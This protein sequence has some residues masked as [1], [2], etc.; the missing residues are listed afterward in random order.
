M[1]DR[2]YERW[3]ELRDREAT[4]SP[5]STLDREFCERMVLEHPLCAREDAML[6]E[7]ADLSATPD[8]GSRE[9]EEA[10]LAAIWN[11]T[12]SANLDAEA[13]AS[14]AR[15]GSSRGY[16]KLAV[17]AFAAVIALAAFGGLHAL[18]D[19]RTSPVADAQPSRVELV[20]TAGNVTVDA[21]AATFGQLLAEGSLVDA[22]GGAACLAMDPGIDLC[23]ERGSSLRVTRSTGS[24]RRVDLL[25]GRVTAAI[26]PQPVG[27]RFSVVADQVWSTAMGTAF[28]VSRGSNKTVE[29]VVL[30]GKVLVGT[31]GKQTPVS[32]HQ[33]AKVI[34]DETTVASIARAE[35]S[36]YW[37]S[38]KTT[39]LWRDPKTA[40]LVITD[41]GSHASLWLNGHELGTSPLSSLIPAGNHHLRSVQAGGAIAEQRFS[42]AAGK[43]WSIHVKPETA[44]E[45]MGGHAEESAKLAVVDDAT[46]KHVEQPGVESQAAVKLVA[47]SELLAQARQQ[48]RGKDWRAAATTYR[49]VRAMHP[50]S[51]E[52]ATVLV[53][54]AKLSLE[55][56]SEPGTA[57]S[58]LDT[59]LASG[60]GS[61]TQEAR[62]LRIDALRR[63]GKSSIASDAARAFLDD[64]PRS[65]QAE[66]LR[67]ELASPQPTAQP[68][69]AQPRPVEP[70]TRAE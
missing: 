12:S 50:N 66:T 15:H 33:R 63:L 34:G 8:S 69:P 41:D 30:S 49:S 20:Y 3:T 40:A 13:N 4:G 2:D 53:S 36:P 37:A 45:S 67:R 17:V 43:T 44:V 54:L 5:L 60:G 46:R 64:Y 29:T 19:S 22:S 10:V 56:L 9:R 14:A 26:A 61:L 1:T 24:D 21:H 39:E 42:V 31:Q 58:D 68:L 18:R 51:A 23:L 57:L 47:A 6:A 65:F 48:L 27:T 35:E 7:L 38:L 70:L 16:P 28:S 62:Y 52:A 32:A 25:H 55:H 11:D 59:Y